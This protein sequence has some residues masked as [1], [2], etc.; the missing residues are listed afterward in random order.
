MLS[1]TDFC[2]SSYFPRPFYVAVHNYGFNI[3]AGT[4]GQYAMNNDKIAPMNS[5]AIADKTNTRIKLFQ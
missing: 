2:I 5:A 4:H 1:Q 3:I